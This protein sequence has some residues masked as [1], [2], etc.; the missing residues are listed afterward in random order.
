MPG[1]RV[2]FAAEA[3]EVAVHPAC[4][5]ASQGDE[6]DDVM[7]DDT[8]PTAPAGHTPDGGVLVGQKGA[9]RTAVVYEDPQCPACK[10]F[11]DVSGDRVRREIASGSL[12]VEYRMMTFIGPGSLLANDALALAAEHGGFDALRQRLFAVQPREGS[13]LTVEQILAAAA[14]AGITDP[15]FEQGL[16]EGR[17][18]EWVLAVGD[19]F[20]ERVQGTPAM[21][22]DGEPVDTAVL[23]DPEALGALL[24]G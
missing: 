24:R 18:E 9:R 5:R 13:Q 21:V 15:D 19:A 11:E 20:G 7:A 22:L 3:T 12:A 17:H 1:A 23:F 10:Q 16:R 8:A 4:R 14:D 6:H 2:W